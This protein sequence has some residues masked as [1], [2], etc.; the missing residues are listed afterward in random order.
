[1]NE[2]TNNTETVNEVEETSVNPEGA[3][4]ETTVE[5]LTITKEEL[6]KRIQSA[7]DKLRTQYSK[8][9]KE[10]EKKITELTPVEKTEAEKEYE[11]RLAALE[12]REKAM[13]MRDALNAKGVSGDFINY[14]RDDADIEAFSSLVSGLIQAKV[15]ERIDGSFKP[16]AHKAGA[17]MTKEDFRKLS[18]AEREKIFNEN[19]DLFKAMTA[20]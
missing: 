18:Y 17:D 8:Q 16:G 7:E 5:T 13:N 3:N 10:L 12:A 14:L 4:T 9:I 19:P 1:M 20:R 15:D 6:D 2:N 11:K